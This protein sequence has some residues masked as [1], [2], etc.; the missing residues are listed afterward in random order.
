MKHKQFVFPINLNIRRLP[1]RLDHSAL[2]QSMSRRNTLRLMGLG[3]ATAAI[4]PILNACGAEQAQGQAP[5]AIPTP[6]ELLMKEI[7]RTQEK[8]PAI[9]MGTFLTFDVLE[10]QPRDNIQ[11]V[12]RHFWKGG[13]P[14]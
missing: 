8:V 1:M 13:G 7:P 6:S 3:A 2:Q 14:A 10:N 11:E 5:P 9:G 4:P 12:M